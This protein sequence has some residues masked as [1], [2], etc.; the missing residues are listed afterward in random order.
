MLRYKRK[1]VLRGGEASIDE[2]AEN[3]LTLDDGMT[4]SLEK[5]PVI[6]F[7]VSTS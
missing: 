5:T 6:E 2:K 3:V 4:L 7:R 1:V